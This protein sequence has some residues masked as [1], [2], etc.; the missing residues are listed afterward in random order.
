MSIIRDTGIGE[1]GDS[2]AAKAA[3]LSGNS[4]GARRV[5]TFRNSVSGVFD[6]MLKSGFSQ[7]QEFEADKNAAALLGAAGYDPKGLT[8]MLQVLRRVQGSQK[9][10]FNSTHPGPAARLAN[11]NS[12]IAGYRV[13]DTRSYRAPRFKN[14]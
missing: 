6:T 13:Q 12:L 11:V 9:G 1:T 10:G 14:K 2:L 4:A 5:L 7:A 8:E 3:N